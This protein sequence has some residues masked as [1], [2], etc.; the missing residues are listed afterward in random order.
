MCVRYHA[1]K[2]PLLSPVHSLVKAVHSSS[3]FFRI[4]L[5]II[6]LLLLRLPSGF[7]PPD[8]PLSTPST[9][10]PLPSCP[11]PLFSVISLITVWWGVQGHVSS[12]SF[13]SSYAQTMWGFVVNLV[14][15]G[16]FFL[17]VLRFPVLWF[18]P[19]ALIAPTLHPHS[20]IHS[21]IHS[22]VTELYNLSNWQRPR[23]T[24]TCTDTNPNVAAHTSR[25]RWCGTE[26]SRV[27]LPVWLGGLRWIAEEVRNVI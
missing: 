4:H 14:T 9:H 24:H 7:F 10:F 19:L 16:Q 8:L 18:S 6:P 5:N 3:N 15:L 2:I 23:V 27:V 13:H 25:H 17:L 12:N 22:S 26:R 1:H 21:F 20:F 11:A